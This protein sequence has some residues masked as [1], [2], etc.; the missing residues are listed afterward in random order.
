MKLRPLQDWAVLVPAE[1]M[2]RTAGGLFIPDSAKEKPREGMVEAVGPGA[3][4]EEKTGR[5]KK[6]GEERKFGPTVVKPGDRVLYETW[7]GQTITIGNEER[8]LVREGSILGLIDRPAAVPATR[9][10]ALPVEQKAAPLACV[11][12]KGSRFDQHGQETD[13]DQSKSQSEGKSQDSG[14][15]KSKAES[16][17]SRQKSSEEGP[18]KE[19]SSQGHEDRQEEIA[20]ELRWK[21]TREYGKRRSLRF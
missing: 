13:E 9:P 6:E 7:A 20:Q 19:K 15:G 12:G 4:E 21:T 16:K 5:K 18:C 3:L 1:A 14:K 17:T 11:T 8:V 2:E 10:S